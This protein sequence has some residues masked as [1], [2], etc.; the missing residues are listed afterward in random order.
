[1]K[2]YCSINE[3][4][5]ITGYTY[6]KITSSSVEFDVI[7]ESK[8]IDFIYD[9]K[10]GNFRELTEDEKMNLFP[11]PSKTDIEILKEENT[12]LKAQVKSLSERGEFIDDCIAEM[13][14]IVY[15]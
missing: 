3:K 7:D 4:G 1:M 11:S 12:L 9:K 6:E 13:A 14:M 15:K 2:I 8:V 10:L 5:L